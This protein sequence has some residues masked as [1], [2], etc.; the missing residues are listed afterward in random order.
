MKAYH[1]AAIRLHETKHLCI[2]CG[3]PFN[4]ARMDAV[5]IPTCPSCNAANKRE[6]EDRKTTQLPMF[7]GEMKC[8]Y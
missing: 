3:E 7:R 2:Q 1:C 8:Q 5:S 6:W 4:W